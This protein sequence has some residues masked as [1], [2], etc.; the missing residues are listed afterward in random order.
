M[1][2]FTNILASM[3]CL[4]LISNVFTDSVQRRSECKHGTEMNETIRRGFMAG[5]MV[6]IPG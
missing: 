4:V 6:G 1:W 2:L 5:A 3:L